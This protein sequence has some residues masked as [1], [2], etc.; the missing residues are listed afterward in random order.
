[1]K[2]VATV[3]AVLVALALAAGVAASTRHA[4]SS[5]ESAAG[6]TNLTVW[7]GWQAR[8]LNEF[9]SVVAEYDKA[10]P[11]V[12]VNVV[13]NI[14]DDKITAAIRSGNAPDVV[15]S[16]TSS[17]VGVYC[18]TGA[19]ID[20][21]P[22]LQ[23]SHINLS[24]FP[25]ASLYYTQ[26]KG[27]RCALPLLADDYGLYYNKTLFKKAGIKS[28]PK[29]FAELSADAKKLTQRGADGS[30]KVVGYDPVWT[31]Y[32]GNAPDMSV[33]FPLFGAKYIDAKGHSI[34]SKDPAWTRLLQWQKSL[35][36]WYGYKN[37]VKFNTGAGQEFSASNA[38]ETGKIA[39]LLDGEWR[40]AF[41]AAEHPELQYGTAPGPVDP[42]HPE[43]YGAGYI[44][45]TIIGIPKGGHNV[46]QAWDL[47]KYLTTNDH[48]LAK[49]SNGIRNVPSTTSSSKSK[50]LKP[51]PHFAT[52][53]RI[54]TNPHS[55]TTPITAAGNAY[56]TLISNFSNKWQAGHVK[57]LK[58]GLAS[59]DKAIDNQLA[60]AEKGGGGPP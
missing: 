1:M 20:L 36:D 12:T 2:R 4:P 48:A 37:L 51:D 56:G 26:Y 35:I 34:L 50:E 49:F 32:S 47:V 38:F 42:A 43:L 58:S 40:V 17:N 45:G 31:F 33:Y 53:L 24:I 23:K 41:I 15:S 54:F 52:F 6:P 9:K 22:F 29:T 19:W 21:A 18:G 8:E 11:D 7:V 30:L 44:N 55:A 27:K 28:P 25:K 46:D 3:V 14:N 57:D 13:G 39:M 59:L 5:A 60:Q 16:F 10:H